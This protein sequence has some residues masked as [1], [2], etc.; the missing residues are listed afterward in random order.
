MHRPQGSIEPWEL[1]DD[2]KEQGRSM[3]H[4]RIG[5]VDRAE[6]IQGFACKSKEFGFC[7]KCIGKPMDNFNLGKNAIHSLFHLTNM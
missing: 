1:K 6:S 4:N 7:S 2:T 3:R 5:E